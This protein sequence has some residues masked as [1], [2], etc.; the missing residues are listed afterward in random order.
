MCLFAT[1]QKEKTAQKAR[2]TFTFTRHD[3]GLKRLR[4]LRFF[5]PEVVGLDRWNLR[6]FQQTLGAYRRYPKILNNG[7]IFSISRWLRVWGMFQGFVG[8]LLDGKAN[9]EHELTLHYSTLA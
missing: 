5:F 6:K 8:I 9:D 4:L 1:S 3:G 2:Q 7:R